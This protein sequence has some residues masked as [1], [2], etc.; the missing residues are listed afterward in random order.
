MLTK[1]QKQNWVDALRS[2]KYEQG[3]SSLRTDLGGYCCLGVFCMTENFPLHENG[4]TIKGHENDTYTFLDSL[5]G[6]GKDHITHSNILVNMNDD[7]R[8]SFAE[9]AD[10]IEQN[11]ETQ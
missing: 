8:K 4:Q 2:G 1:E 10:Y 5:L 3:T 11:I 9:I 6:I 7:K